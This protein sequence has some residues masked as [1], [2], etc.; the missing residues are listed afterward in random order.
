MFNPT[1]I[2]IGAFTRELREVYDR[3]Y[4]TLEPGFPGVIGFVAQ[5]ALENIATSDAPYHD[6][7]HTIMVTLV[8]QEIL[9]GKHISVGGISPRDW[10]HFIISLLCHDIG[11]VRGICQGDGNGQYVSNLGR[12]KVGLPEGATD[13]SLTPYHVAPQP[14]RQVTDYRWVSPR[15]LL[16]SHIDHIVE[17]VEVAEK[18]VYFAVISGEVANSRSHGKLFGPKSLQWRG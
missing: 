16:A 4:G 9:R 1:Q 18:Q 5:L 10:L 2:V 6:V 17:D 13:A 3:N 8:G 14:R 15:K 12:D 7:S 11:Y